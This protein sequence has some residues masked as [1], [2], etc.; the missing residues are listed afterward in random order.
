MAP[1]AWNSRKPRPT[2]WAKWTIDCVSSA[3][4]TRPVAL[5]SSTSAASRAAR[6]T[7]CSRSEPGDLGVAT[8][9]RERF[10]QQGLTRLRFAGDEV[11]ADRGEQV[12]GPAFEGVL[13][14]ELVELV[15]RARLDGLGEQI[16]L[17]GEPAVDGAGGEAGPAGDLGD[18][19]TLVALLGE[20][21]GGREDQPFAGG[22][23]AGLDRG[24]G[25]SCR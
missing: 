8:S 13:G 10:E 3:G 18:A 7:R 14:E 12:G 19:G 21:L 9:G 2:A 22:I 25:H 1:T 5:P 20:H 17:P 16:G 4:S 23:A 15:L 6:S 11:R 24:E